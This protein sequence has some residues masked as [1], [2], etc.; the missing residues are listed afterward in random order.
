MKKLIIPIGALLLSNITYAQLFTISSNENYIQS[1]TYLDYN[2]TSATKSSETVQYFDGLGRPKQV[3]NVKASP[4]GRDVVT[5]IEYDPF[6]RQV[7][8]YLPVPQLSTSNGNYYSGPLGVYPNTYGNEKIYSEK[9]LESS[10]LDRVLEQKQVGNDWNGKSVKF[11]YDTNGLNE[12]YQFTTSTSWVDGATKSVL[13]LSPATV[14][15]PNQL[16]KNSVKDE[17]GNETIEFKNGR[18]QIVLVR[19]VMSPAENVDTYYVYNEYDQLA[20]VIPPLAVHKPITDDLLNT[21]CYQYHYDGRGRLVEKKLPG[22]GWEFMVYDKAD[23][24]M[25][26]QDANMKGSGKWLMTKYDEFGRVA[27]TGIFSSNDSRATIQDQIKD[28]V[29]YDARHS[30]GIVRNGMNIYYTAVYFIPE[31]ILSVNYYDSYPAY[32][33]NPAFP[34]TIQ[35]EPVLTETPAADG[36]STK[37]L[38]VM[39][40]VKN[41]EDDNWT[42]NYTYYDQKGRAIGSHSVNHLGGYTRTESKLD[43]AGITKQTVTRHK[44]LSTDTERVITETFDY[45]SQ[46][47]LVT[48]KHKIDNN[49]EEILAQ[50]TYNE[51][52]QVTNKKVG[53]VTAS[54]PLQQIDYKYNI[55]GWLTQINDPANLG[56]DLFGYKI[57]Y[58]EVQGLEVPNTNYPNHKVKPKYNGNIAEVDWKTSTGANDNVRRYGYVYDPL[59]RLT[60]GFYQKDTNPSGKEYNELFAYDLNGNILNLV[61]TQGLLPGS[62]EA[63]VIDNLIYSYTGN[64]LTKVSDAYLNS[65]GYPVGGNE[66]GYDDNGNMTTQL[67]KGIS[68]IQY[69]YLNLPR[70]ITQNS[71]VMDYIYRADGV[72]VKKVFGTETT[73]YLDG[74]QYTNSILKF[75]PTAEGYFNVETGKYVYNYTDHLGNTRLSYAKNGAGTEIIEESNYY[76]FGLKHE[77]YNVL[78]GNPSYKYKYN[79]KELQET[80]MYDYGARFYMPD[81]GRWG[82][83]DP[84]AEKMTRHSP[85]NYAFNNP[86]MFIDPDGREGKDWYQNNLTQNIEWHDGSAELDGYTNLTAINNTRVLGVENGQT[87]QE[88][89]LNSDGSF[90]AGGQTFNNGESATTLIGTTITS[91]PG[92][93]L[94]KWLSHLGNEGGDFYS[95]L[96]G[97]GPREDTNPFFRGDIDKMVDVGGYFGG[98]HN[99]LSRGDQ[100]I[101]L[102]NTMVDVMS[103]IDLAVS[104]AGSTKSSSNAVAAEPDTL[105]YHGS[106]AVGLN[107]YRG[108]GG[109]ITGVG[110]KTQDIHLSGL[111]RSQRDSVSSRVSADE[112]KRNNQKD[113]V[114]RRIMKSR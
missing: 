103:L 42:R 45:D 74:F 49:A 99:G 20:F 75:F 63:M 92:F 62:T 33:F 79:G 3:V 18:G 100:G 68:S 54:S 8:D 113:S 31:S 66:I 83:I 4:L 104:A 46:N 57:K 19:K 40:F 32:S 65:L 48:H 60:A 78:T 44:R 112:I 95:N 109:G 35:G 9:V 36:R 14:Y 64:R 12:V 56:N 71:K 72:K 81:I 107:I 87:V 5:H 108:S 89:N 7:K 85:Y 59:N 30:T 16:Y 84:L 106:Q 90:T 43:F 73:D 23:R 70:K 93:D 6:G 114:L 13:S 29:I 34:S 37:G 26:T 24:L 110:V 67:D 94:G 17:D 86:I 102:M 15:A 97:S 55:R 98:I 51:I 21:L 39:S 52:S 10:P 80:G 2:G 50:N 38:P 69:N 105:S 1:K 91:K 28:L 96:G 76:P 53:G 82:V 25:L 47:R 77:G 111:S 22:K 11:S 58:N 27:Y 101:S 61:R 88:F 41:I